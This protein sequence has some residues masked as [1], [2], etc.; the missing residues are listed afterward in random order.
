MGVAA[1]DGRGPKAMSECANADES[2]GSNPVA[3]RDW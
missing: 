1:T 2:N 3:G